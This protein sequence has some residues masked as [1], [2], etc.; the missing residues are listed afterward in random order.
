MKVSR[1]ASCAPLVMGGPIAIS[2]AQA[3][4]A[5]A[6]GGC[7]VTAATPYSTGKTIYSASS[8]NCRSTIE[9]LVSWSRPGPDATLARS[10]HFGY[11]ALTTHAC[12]W[13]WPANRN[14][15]TTGIRSGEKDTSPVRSFTSAHSTCAL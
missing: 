3:D 14:I 12:T 8:S 10:S 1:L 6:A 7:T 15:Y 11:K 4:L 13:G 2:V 9:S 5:S